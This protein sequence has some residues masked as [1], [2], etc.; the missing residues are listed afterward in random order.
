MSS[1][2]P[3]S[4]DERQ[5]D[6]RISQEYHNADNAEDNDFNDIPCGRVEYIWTI[7]SPKGGICIILH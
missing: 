7:D 2:A 1:N 5:N 6:K 4:F 3:W